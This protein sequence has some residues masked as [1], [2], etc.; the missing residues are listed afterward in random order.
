[1]ARVS[2][3]RRNPKEFGSPAIDMSDEEGTYEKRLVTGALS[4]LAIALCACIWVMRVAWANA[5]AMPAY[6]T[7]DELEGKSFA[8]VNGSVYDKY[9][10]EKIPNTSE[11]FFPTLTDAVTAVESGKVDAAYSAPTPASWR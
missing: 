2:D 9:I 3:A 1:M 6:Q 11:S 10:Q 7:L 5:E 8:Y 4:V